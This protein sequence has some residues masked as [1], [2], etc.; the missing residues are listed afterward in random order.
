[1]KTEKIYEGIIIEESLIDSKYMNG[2]EIIKTE[3]AHNG[4]WT[5]RTVNI[6][7]EKIEYLSGKIKSNSYYMHF[8]NNRDVIVVFK[9]KTFEID[10]DNKE[11]WE[12]AIE[13]GIS[14]GIPKEQLDFPIE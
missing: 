5:L 4:Q 3:I 10:Y 6:T 9:D 7:K 2:I 13:Y 8:W 12:D 11:T 14:I 1:M